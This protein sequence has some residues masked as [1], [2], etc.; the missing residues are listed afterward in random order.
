MIHTLTITD[1][2]FCFVT[3]KQEQGNM[4]TSA[5]THSH[6]L[7]P[8]TAVYTQPSP[9]HPQ[10]KMNKKRRPRGHTAKACPTLQKERLH[11]QK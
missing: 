6:K 11:L 4:Y 10:K 9:P 3:L 2:T 7:G 5:Q 8:S 1:I